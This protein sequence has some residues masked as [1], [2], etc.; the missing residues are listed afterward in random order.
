ML[1]ECY[2]KL[3]CWASPLR[4][5]DSIDLGWGQKICSSNKFP[6]DV[7]TAG[8][9]PTLGFPKLTEYWNHLGRGGAPHQICHLEVWEFIFSNLL[10]FPSVIVMPCQ[11]W[12]LLRCKPTCEG[13][14]LPPVL[15]IRCHIWKCQHNHCNQPKSLLM[16]V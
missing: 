15:Y 10:W 16:I 4:V 7:N 5:S 14:T 1:F 12:A 8:P 11:A 13:L 9:G 3:D 2:I 6:G